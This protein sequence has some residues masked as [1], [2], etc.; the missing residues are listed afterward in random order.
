MHHRRSARTV[1]RAFSVLGVGASVVA[2]TVTVPAPALA[3]PNA[4]RPC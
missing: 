1:L 2:L 3:A 4:N